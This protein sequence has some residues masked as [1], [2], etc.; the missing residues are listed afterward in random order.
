LLTL[1][2]GASP[3]FCPGNEFAALVLLPVSPCRVVLAEGIAPLTDGVLL[4]H[5]VKKPSKDKA[6]A[7][8]TK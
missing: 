5:P 8:T 6:P 4:P 3:F 7:P 1:P 2:A